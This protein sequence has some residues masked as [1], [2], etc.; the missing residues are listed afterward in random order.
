[1]TVFIASSLFANPPHSLHSTSP[2]LFPSSPSPPSPSSLPFSSSPSLPPP[3]TL[4]HHRDTL[5]ATTTQKYWIDVQLR[6]GDF[7]SHDVERYARAKFLDYTTDNMSFY[8]SPTGTMIAMDLAYSLYRWL[9]LAC[10]CF[11]GTRCWLCVFVVMFVFV[12]VFV[13]DVFVCVVIVVHNVC[14]CCS[15]D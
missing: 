9:M 4:P 12:L 13:F 8:P 1:M 7:D 5:D 2:H 14:V 11:K 15:F 3:N 10:C 6:W